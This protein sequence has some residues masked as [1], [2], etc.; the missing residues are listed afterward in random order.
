[1][2]INENLSPRQDVAYS[3]GSGFRIA[4]DGVSTLLCSVPLQAGSFKKE[5]DDA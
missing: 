1:M 4:D 3:C 5:A 2:K